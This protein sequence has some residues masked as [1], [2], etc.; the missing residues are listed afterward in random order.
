MSTNQDDK[1]SINLSCLTISRKIYEAKTK[2]KQET[3]KHS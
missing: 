2:F 3:D 1:T